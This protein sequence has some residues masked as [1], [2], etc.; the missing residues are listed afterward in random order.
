MLDRL[1]RNLNQKIYQRKVATSNVA[2]EQEALIKAEEELAE[3]QQAQSY[4][5]EIAQTTQQK[6]HKQIAKVVSK[7]L[8]AVFE[9]PYEL[10]IEFDRKRDRTEAKFVYYRDGQKLNPYITSGGVRDV[11]SLA[12]RIASL[13]LSLPPT[14]RLLVLDEPFT[15]LSA[16]NK[17]KIA[18]LLEILSEELKM[19]FILTT[20]DPTFRIGK[21]IEL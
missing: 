14:R 17:P 19:Q 13:I 16:G 6:S 12:L 21:V 1:R 7:C 8:S 3:I 20:H 18:R 4:L 15:A 5:Q 11:A 9:K 2:L 10:K